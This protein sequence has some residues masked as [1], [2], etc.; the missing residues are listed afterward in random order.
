MARHPKNERVT[1]FEKIIRSGLSETDGYQ[2]RR[3][4]VLSNF[5]ALILV[6]AILVIYLSSLLFFGDNLIDTLIIGTVLFGSPI[7][8]NLFFS[9]SLSRLVLCYAPVI[10]IWLSFLHPLQKI[11]MFQLNI[12]GLRTYLLA[13]CFIPYLLFD[14]STLVFL[15]AGILPTLLSFLF[16]REILSLAGVDHENSGINA[17]DYQLTY[18]R[19]L[20]A[21]V[22][23]S[24]SCFTFQYIITQNDRFNQSLLL[25]L[26]NQNEMIEAQNDKLI[27]N[28]DKLNGINQHLE[29]LVEKKTA[30]IRNQ[31]AVLLKH[32]YR[33]AHHVRGPVARI[34]GLIQISKMNTDLNYRWLIDRMEQ[35]TNEIDGIVKSISQELA[36]KD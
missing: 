19:S 36:Q 26:K 17:G 15:I 22:I 4:I 10:F 16:F 1:I 25:R 9:S 33:N 28:Q 20:V 29:D 21:Y 18:L 30:D 31:N 2:R 5:L 13:V 14:R 3:S 12:Y 27:L 8:I 34:L 24:A 7:L 11:E 35:E 6:G 23:I 32:A